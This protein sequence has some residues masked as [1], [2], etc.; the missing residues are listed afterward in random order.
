MIVVALAQAVYRGFLASTL[1]AAIQ[2]YKI[3]L[4]GFNN[5]DCVAIRFLCTFSCSFVHARDRCWVH[6]FSF[7]GTII[8]EKE[9][10]TIKTTVAIIRLAFELKMHTCI[11]VILIVCTFSVEI[12]ANVRRLQRATQFIR[13][14]ITSTNEH[15]HTSI[16]R[17]SAGE[18]ESKRSFSRT[19][20]QLFLC[21]CVCVESHLFPC[22]LSHTHTP[23]DVYL[24]ISSSATADDC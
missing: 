15:P 9:T 13:H 2:F 22:S 19:V 6:N 8:E 4:I 14:H 18:R 21:V 11:G 16:D 3:F 20:K 7:S 1:N 24:R 10:Q 17:E 23:V 12:R 5:N